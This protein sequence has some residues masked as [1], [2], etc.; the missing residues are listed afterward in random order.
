MRKY[1]LLSLI[2]FP[3]FSMSQQWKKT[4]K[5][6]LLGVGAAN[7]LG[8][9]GGADQIGTHLMKDLEI[10][11]TRP[12]VAAGYRYKL[13]PTM[14]VKGYTGWARLAGNDLLTAEPSR[15]NRNLSFRT[16]IIT[17]SAQFEYS[18]IEEKVK[19][20]YSRRSKK[21]PLNIYFFGG[22]G[23]FYFNPESQ[24]YDGKWY[25]LKPLRTEGQGLP[26]SEAKDYSLV[27]FCVPLGVGFK[28]PINREWSI[29]LEYSITKTFT[30][31][32]DDVSTVYYDNEAIRAAYGDVAA[33]FADPSTTPTREAPIKG[34]T[35]PGEKRGETTYNDSFMF[36]WLNV[37]YKITGTTKSRVKF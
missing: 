29:G 35:N 12:T 26:G 24:Y 5:E 30:D 28:Y 17:A 11:L 32:I 13:S 23:L 9:L 15:N 36:A 33:Y 14:A 21:F 37:S 8:D 2:L 10:S 25:K 20:R 18:V 22:F 31:Y 6:I 16:N 19:S 34:G 7:L 1:I 27:Q 3:L 4:R